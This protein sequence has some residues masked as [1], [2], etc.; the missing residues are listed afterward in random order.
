MKDFRPDGAVNEKQFDLAIATRVAVD[1]RQQVQIRLCVIV[2]CGRLLH[3]TERGLILTGEFCVVSRS[4][5]VEISLVKNIQLGLNG[6]VTD[7]KRRY[8]DRDPISVETE[9]RIVDPKFAVGVGG[10]SIEVPVARGITGLRN[11]DKG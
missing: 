8:R 3:N 10:D 2:G 4:T 11:P 7:G 1:R 6:A 5:R 9:G